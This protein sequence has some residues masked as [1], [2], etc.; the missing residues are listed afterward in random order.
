MNVNI[1]YFMIV[2]G[3]KKIVET[4]QRFPT[5]I[6]IS[7]FLATSMSEGVALALAMGEHTRA[8]GLLLPKGIYF[9]KA[10]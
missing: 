7:K 2:E 9:E 5:V 10:S 3:K 1:Q 8:K 4:P 6:D